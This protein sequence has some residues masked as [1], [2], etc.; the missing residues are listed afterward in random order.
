MRPLSLSAV[1]LLGLAVCCS[2]W[3]PALSALFRLE[4]DAPGADG[5]GFI[6]PSDGAPWLYKAVSLVDMTQFGSV[7]DFVPYDCVLLHVEG[8]V[9]NVTAAAEDSYRRDVVAPGKGYSLKAVGDALLLGAAQPPLTSYFWMEQL[10]SGGAIEWSYSTA[11]GTWV[12]LNGGH[13]LPHS[14]AVLGPGG[15]FDLDRGGDYAPGATGMDASGNPNANRATWWETAGRN[16]GVVAPLPSDLAAVRIP[17]GG[18][19]PLYWLRGQVTAAFATPPVIN[20]VYDRPDFGELLGRKYGGKQQWAKATAERLHGWGFTATGQYSYAYVDAAPNLDASARLPAIRSWQMSGWAERNEAPGNTSAGP[21]KIVYDGAVCPPSSTKML[22][23]GTQADVW[24]PAYP[25]SLAASAAF[26]E[27]GSLVDEWAPFLVVDEADDLFGFDSLKHTH[28]GYAVLSQNPFHP[29]SIKVPSAGLNYSDPRMFAKYAMRDFLRDR[30]RAESDD[31]LPSFDFKKG[32]PQ[33]AYAN[34]SASAAALSKLNAAWNTS[35]TSWDTT[36]GDIRAGNGSWGTGTGWMDE[37]GR[38]AYN[39]SCTQIDYV[40]SAAKSAA[41]PGLWRDLEDFVAASVQRYGYCMRSALNASAAGAA[42]VPLAFMI[43]DGPTWVYKNLA[44]YADLFVTSATASRLLEIY[45]ASRRPLVDTDYT[46]AT[47]DSAMWS[48][49]NISALEF[50]ASSG[51][52][53]ARVPGFKYR[54]RKRRFVTWPSAAGSFMTGTPP[55]GGC[56]AKQCPCGYLT[57]SAP[58][59]FVEWDTLYWANDYV[60]V[61]HYGECL[62]SGGS[63]QISS[64]SGGPPLYNITSQHDRASAMAD[65]WSS[66]RKLKGSDGKRFVIGFE[67]WGLHD[68]QPSNWLDDENFGLLTSRDNAYD[69]TEARRARATV[70]GKLVGGELGDYGDFVTPFSAFLR[71]LK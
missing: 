43:Y 70:D 40:Q 15:R 1:P 44:P 37:D 19:L 28:M 67:H 57:T 24:D 14:G 16:G 17:G 38:A 36:T 56:H 68:P 62:H 11:N 30:Y 12:P 52:T 26:N 18:Q 23:Q 25:I 27:G 2:C 35:Y 49:G 4:A 21:V 29:R 71:G 61:T 20:Q 48:E 41:G 10:G 6:S 54:W 39:G 50:N 32:T 33:F 7:G 45:E 13:G 63:L 5:W 34:D 42:H 9:H 51:K 65:S 60:N 55:L 47:P 53:Q 64:S 3:Q 31:P 59:G 22:W 58:L 66:K 8:I 69:G 46:V